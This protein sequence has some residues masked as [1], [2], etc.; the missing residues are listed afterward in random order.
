VIE[1]GVRD[2]IAPVDV[3][4]GQVA[5]PNQMHMK[6]IDEKQSPTAK[7]ITAKV[8]RQILYFLPVEVIA[9]I[10]ILTGPIAVAAKKP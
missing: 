9:E 8:A 4:L 6:R 3:M 7:K 5:A 1:I 10:V 2:P